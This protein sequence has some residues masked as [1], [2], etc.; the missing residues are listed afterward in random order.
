MDFQIIGGGIIGLSTAYA[1][2]RKGAS[3]RVIE[4]GEEVA[5]QTSFAN[6]GMIHC[7]LVDPWNSPGIGRQILASLFGQ[8]SPIKLKLSSL[9][10]L[11]FWGLKFIKH[12][13]KALHLK[14]VRADYALAQL[15]DNT[16]TKWREELNPDDDFAASGILKIFRD[17]ESFQT[18][19]AM[20]DFICQMGLEAEILTPENIIKKDKAL[21]PIQ[22]NL[23]GGIYYPND[24]KADCHKFA[25]TLAI[26]I[27]NNGGEVL[28]NLA[29]TGLIKENGRIIGAKTKQGLMRANTTIICAGPFTNAVLKPFTALSL[30]P[31]KGYSLHFSQSHFTGM[32]MPTIPVI[33]ETLHCAI[34][35]LSNGLRIAGTA[36]LC[37]FDNTMGKKQLS[38]LLGMLHD[39]YPKLAKD[40]RLDD[41]ARWQGF[42]PVSAD[43]VPFIG[44]LADGLYVN[45]GHG[46][47]GWTLSAGS[48]QLLSE[49]LLGETPSISLCPYKPLR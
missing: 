11:G 23:V 31:V 48:A 20:T 35:P 33:D 3:V 16:F 22:D 19:K 1:L 12:S 43:G 39:V 44:K 14:A 4:A 27:K 7:S 17:Q 6:A 5:R 32:A 41:A 15:S 10:S 21:S 34:T 9:A 49:I 42:R 30:R 40:L 18:A 47:L 38:P 46:H 13:S 45:T 25:Q 36:H 8:A 28:T 37:G 26:E 29:V 24:S 2:A